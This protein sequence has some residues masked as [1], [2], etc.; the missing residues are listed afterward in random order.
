M[1]R[2]YPGQRRNKNEQGLNDL[3]DYFKQSN[4]HVIRVPEGEEEQSRGEKR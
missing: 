2:N 1:N 3:I 4:I